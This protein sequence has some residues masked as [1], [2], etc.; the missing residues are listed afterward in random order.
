MHGSNLGRE[1]GRERESISEVSSF[2]VNMAF[3][4]S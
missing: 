3:V 2:A 1:I 4:G